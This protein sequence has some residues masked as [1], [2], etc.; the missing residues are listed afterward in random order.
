MNDRIKAALIKRAASRIHPIMRFLMGQGI[1]KF[2]LAGSSMN[3]GEP[4][5]IDL[6][7]L[8]GDFPK[9]SDVGQ[10]DFY[11]ITTTPN[12]Q[13]IGLRG[14]ATRDRVVVQLCNYR[15]K[16]LGALVRSFDF[17][18][19]QV[20][21]SI[22]LN[23]EPGDFVKKVFF[24][25]EWVEAQALGTTWFTGSEYPL[26]SLVRLNKYYAQGRLK[27]G[28]MMGATVNIL[29][30]VV[31]RGFASPVDFADQLDAV[32][33][34]LLEDGAEEWPELARLYEVLGERR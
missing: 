25:D 33:W 17:A 6:F 14:T 12:A 26:S 10:E 3:P 30:A 21:A 9:V 4:N 29:A 18:H 22:D 31:S 20:G 15:H 34:G 19:V 23:A 1:N 13:T 8:G 7:P 32:D 28:A 11:V 24:T 27:Y 5:D 2:R 16:S